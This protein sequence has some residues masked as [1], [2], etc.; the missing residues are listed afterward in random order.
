MTDNIRNAKEQ[1][2]AGRDAG[3]L[4]AVD[5]SLPALTPVDAYLPDASWCIAEGELNEQTHYGYRTAFLVGKYRGFL[6]ADGAEFAIRRSFC[7]SALSPVKN[8]GTKPIFSRNVDG[9]ATKQWELLV[10]GCVQAGGSNYGEAMS[11]IRLMLM[12]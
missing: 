2:A 7:P 10:G 1:I 5:A 11:A 9:P 3:A 6:T 12:L 4:T 8:P